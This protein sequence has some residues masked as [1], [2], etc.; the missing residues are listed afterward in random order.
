MERSFE[1]KHNTN[2]RIVRYDKTASHFDIFMVSIRKLPV[3][4]KFKRESYNDLLA[5][6][7]TT[8]G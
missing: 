2:F 1:N 7:S 8:F 3:K 6:F 4:L 5:Y